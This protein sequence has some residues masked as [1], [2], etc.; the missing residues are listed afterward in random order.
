MV[1]EEAFSSGGVGGCNTDTEA[2]TH[3]KSK[4]NKG[5]RRKTDDFDTP[6]S[7]NTV[8]SLRNYEYS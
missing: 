2:K 7:T 3:R 8:I 4:K 5:P 1:G 6:E